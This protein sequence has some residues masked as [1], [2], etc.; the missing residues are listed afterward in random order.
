M[1][2]DYSY[3][4]RTSNEEMFQ[5]GATWLL[6]FLAGVG[7]GAALMYF[8]DPER[9]RR[10]RALLRDQAVGLTN[11]ARQAIN[12]TSQDLSNRA[13]GL[14]A[15]TRKAVTGTPV[16]STAGEQSTGSEMNRSETGLTGRSGTDLTNLSE[17][18]R[19][20]R[21]ETGLTHETSS[22]TD[23]TDETNSSEFG[24]SATGR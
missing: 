19:T 13:Y 2:N 23:L 11:D 10:R 20:D 9:G 7:T 5:T 22:E 3:Q 18:G 8:M 24:R 17:T 12:S 6:P 21:S 16:S 14:Y 4:E 15:E 1:R